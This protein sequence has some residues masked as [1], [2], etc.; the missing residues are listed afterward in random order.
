MWIRS[1][2]RQSRHFPQNRAHS[3][4]NIGDVE[5]TLNQC[6][7]IAVLCWNA[8]H[9]ATTAVRGRPQLLLEAWSP[10]EVWISGSV[11]TNN[12]TIHFN[13]NLTRSN[14]LSPVDAHFLLLQYYFNIVT[15]ND[16]RRIRF[17]PHW[18]QCWVD[19]HVS[20]WR[21]PWYFLWAI[22]SKGQRFEPVKTS[23][24]ANHTYGDQIW[25]RFITYVLP[26]CVWASLAY[27]VHREA[28]NPSTISID[29]GK[30]STTF[31]EA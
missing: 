31:I 22:T 25:S 20:D 1:G 6:F 29:A 26:G 17:L 12:I 16:C 19:G 14:L 24:T 11:T 15:Y 18:W 9:A 13:A 3:R 2:A 10:G 4:A 28:Y 21:A 5:P 23:C 8:N 27:T 30:H 7:G